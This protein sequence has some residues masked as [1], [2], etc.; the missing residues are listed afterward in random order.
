MKAVVVNFHVISALTKIKERHIACCHL[1]EGGMGEKET[2]V[3]F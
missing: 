2:K 3:P 1:E